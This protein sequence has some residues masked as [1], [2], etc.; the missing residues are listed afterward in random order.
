MLSAMSYDNLIYQPPKACNYKKKD[1]QVTYTS[2]NERICLKVF[3]PFVWTPNAA[4]KSGAQLDAMTQPQPM[5]I[6]SHGNADDIGTA[7]PYC[8]WLADSL[9]LQVLTYDYVG[10]GLSEEKETSEDSMY[11]AIAA[12]HTYATSRLGASKIILVGKSLGSVPTVFVASDKK[13]QTIGTILISGLASGARVLLKPEYVPKIMMPKLDKLFAPNIMRI[14]NVKHKVLFIH[15]K[16]DKTVPFRNSEELCCK[17]S[18]D[19]YYPPLWLDADHNDIEDKFAS[20][21]IANISTFIE[22]VNQNTYNAYTV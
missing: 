11:R 2:H 20:L 16:Q 18:A 8:Q 19:A 5:I 21:F 10:Y 13:F 1:V 14:A 6:F 15:G 3:Q 17:L 12:V 7:G 9:G 22:S 4:A